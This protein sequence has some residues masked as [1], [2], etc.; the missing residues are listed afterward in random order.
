M[1]KRNDLRTDSDWEHFAQTDPYWA[2]LTCDQFRRGNL[3]AGTRGAFF[4]SGEE[5]IGW[6]ELTARTHLDPGFAPRRALDF[7]CGVGRLLLPLAKRCAEVVGVDVSD[8]MLREAETNCR[9]A[10]VD[11]VTLVKGDDELSGVAGH[12]DLVHTLMVLQH[13]PVGRGVRLFR[14]LVD[15]VGPG[16][17]GV[18]HVTYGP[19]LYQ[20][21][22]RLRALAGALVRPFRSRPS[23]EPRM[24]MNLYPLNDLIQI[25]QESGAPT[26]HA[27]YMNQAGH[28]SVVLLFRKGE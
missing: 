18:L 3:D 15:L 26:I 19:P 10:G 12:F 14:R 9:T 8:T 11:N 13:I 7:G 17:C 5:H 24:Q 1:P 2:V 23:D 21:K 4:E 16:G 22:N 20:A 25:V 6:V 28:Y 27:A